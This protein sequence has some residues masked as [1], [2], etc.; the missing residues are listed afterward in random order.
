[1]NSSN[2]A[3]AVP[4][5]PRGRSF[6][7]PPLATVNTVLRLLMVLAIVLTTTGL[8]GTRLLDLVLP[9]QQRVYALLMIDFKV[10][11][12]DLAHDAGHLVVRAL[13]VSQ[14]YLVI[15]GQAYPPGVGLSAQTPA[16]VALTYAALVLVGVLAIARGPW[17]RL[18][19]AFAT[20]G[21]CAGLL[22]CC[23]PPLILAGQQWA[24]VVEPFGEPSLS[25]LLGGISD[26]LLHG[27]GYAVAALAVVLIRR[28]STLNIG[29][30]TVA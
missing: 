5:H 18:A 4:L 8:F 27:G 2:S 11:R 9:W 13:A 3:P 17:Q 19:T 14:R 16:R 12:F 7:K 1:M 15:Q 21:L 10:Y 22:L 30:A 28:M 29:G 6:P 20:A 25:A 24:T 23:V 26:I